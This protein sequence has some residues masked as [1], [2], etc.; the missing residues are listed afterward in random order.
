MK[1]PFLFLCL[2]LLTLILFRGFLFRQLISYHEIGQRKAINITHPKLIKCIDAQLHNQQMDIKE[3]ARIANKV[4][5]QELRFTAKKV[6]QNPNDLINSHQANC[7]GYASMFNTIATHLIKKNG[8]EKELVAQHK[9][10]HLYLLGFN[11]HS[12]FK[13]PFFMDHDFNQIIHLKTKEVIAIDPT[14]SDYLW[15]NCITTTN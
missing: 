11:L 12:F 15:I 8:L 1:K 9:I 5:T 7:V 4:T 2:T 14:V 6:S 3:I 13:S 10:G